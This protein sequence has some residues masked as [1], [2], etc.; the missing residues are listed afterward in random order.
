MMD[1]KLS[2][3]EVEVLLTDNQ[4]AYISQGLQGGEKIITTNLSTVAEGIALRTEQDTTTQNNVSEK[5]SIE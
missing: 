4:Y 1:G 5:D 3:K 2:I